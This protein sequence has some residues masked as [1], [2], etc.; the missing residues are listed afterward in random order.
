MK[1]LNQAVTIGTTAPYIQPNPNQNMQLIKFTI[2]LAA[3]A[4]ANVANAQKLKNKLP[5]SVKKE[6]KDFKEIPADTVKFYPYKSKK[7]EEKAKTV[8]N[9][10]IS[11]FEVT[12]N[13]WRAFYTAMVTK[14]GKDEAKRFL[15]DTTVWTKS[16]PTA[17]NQMM[18]DFYYGNKVYG[19]YPVVG[20]TWNQAKAYADWKTDDINNKLKAKGAKY[21]VV[22]RLPTANEWDYVAFPIKQYIANNVLENV[23]EGGYGDYLWNLNPYSYGTIDKHGYQANFGPIM[24]TTGFIFKSFVDDGGFYPLPARCYWPNERGL[25]NIRGNVEEWVSDESTLPQ[26]AGPYLNI[27][28]PNPVESNTTLHL[29]KGGSWYDGPYY[30]SME[31]AKSYPA[32]TSSPL[33]GLRLAM[34]IV[35]AKPTADK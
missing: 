7:R 2:L 22:M 25:Y 5:R 27:M 11:A 28:Q 32:N 10:Y 20:I 29:A 9:F 14:L 33:T 21:S 6:L 1:K 17:S 30:L 23:I 16:F 12:N 3:I 35:V 19:K 15:P 18:V 4:F 31:A 8:S 34:D 24:D 26:T 13:D